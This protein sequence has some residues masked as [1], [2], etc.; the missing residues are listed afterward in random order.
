[1]FL[2]FE[3]ET[4]GLLCHRNTGNTLF[5]SYLP[6]RLTKSPTEK[7]PKMP[8]IEKIATVM[9]Q[10]AVSELLVMGSW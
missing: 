5:A 1:M 8:P 9:D 6:K 10:I 3:K 4:L 2:F 7:E